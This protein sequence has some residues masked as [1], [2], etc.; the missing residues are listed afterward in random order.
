ML[1]F[2]EN[3]GISWLSIDRA[4][5]I[6]QR[7]AALESHPVFK[8]LPDCRQ[9]SEEV[10]SLT[11]RKYDRQYPRGGPPVSKYDQQ[12]TRG[13]RPAVSKEAVG[14]EEDALLPAGADPHL[15]RDQGRG[16][17]HVEERGQQRGGARLVPG[18]VP[19]RGS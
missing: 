5:H 6:H 19:C 2:F 8:T 4:K 16:A 15:V 18:E 9:L 3:M 11:H 1:F 14:G 10:W 13:G 12:Y 17:R 7:R